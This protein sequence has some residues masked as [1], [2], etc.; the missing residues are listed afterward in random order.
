MGVVLGI[1]YFFIT[2]AYVTAVYIYTYVFILFWKPCKNFIDQTAYIFLSVRFYKIVR[3][4]YL[5]S[6]KC[7]VSRCGC[8]YDEAFFV[9]VSKFFAISIPF[10][11]DI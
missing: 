4:T 3:G 9:E 5:K 7:M 2:Q 11:P 1:D 6:F 8:E 10:A